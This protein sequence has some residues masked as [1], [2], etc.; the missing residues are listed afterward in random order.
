MSTLKVYSLKYSYSPFQR[1]EDLIE[2]SPTYDQ[3]AKVLEFME[4]AHS[5]LCQEPLTIR[6]KHQFRNLYT[7]EMEKVPAATG[8]Y[9]IDEDLEGDFRKEAP[10]PDPYHEEDVV[11]IPASIDFDDHP[12]GALMNMRRRRE[13]PDALIQLRFLEHSQDGTMAKMISAKETVERVLAKAPT[14]CHVALQGIK[15][16]KSGCEMIHRDN[17]RQEMCVSGLLSFVL[18]LMR[19]SPRSFVVQMAG[20]ECFFKLVGGYGIA[21]EFAHL[22]K[23]GREANAVSSSTRNVVITMLVSLAAVSEH[24]LKSFVGGMKCIVDYFHTHLPKTQMR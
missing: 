2:F 14:S 11:H 16:I 12:L 10:F 19:I 24:G 3:V 4:S 13:F 7:D 5:Y 8:E 18:R 6:E 20:V 21:P 17:D 9:N 1:F 15:V 23:S 22:D